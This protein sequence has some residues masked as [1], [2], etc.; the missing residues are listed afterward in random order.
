MTSPADSVIALYQAHADAFA[1]LRGRDLMERAW[2]D[3]FLAAMPPDGRDVLDL[4]CGNGRPIAE[5][6]IAQ[7]CRVTGVDG[8]AAMTN[9]ARAAFPA[10]R[11]IT[12]D[13]RRL[14][15][16]GRFHG[17]LAWHSFFHLTPEAQR[18]MLA[19]F[20]RLAHPGAAL[21]FTSG[22][23]E[24]E[25]IGRFEGLPLYHGSLD[26]ADYVARLREAGLEVLRHVAQDP[27]CGHATIWLARKAL[28]TG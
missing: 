19:A 17:V 23:A 14:P 1:A 28:D 8:A 20:G 12:A 10:H 24:G 6:L 13:M 2:L 9:R 3:A 15:P 4:G 7:G 16:L 22:P 27:S 18:P 11:W 25:A 26:P 5:Y 21:M